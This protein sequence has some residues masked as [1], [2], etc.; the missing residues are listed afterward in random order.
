[1][2]PWEV[3]G[4]IFGQKNPNCIVGKTDDDLGKPFPT[5]TGQRS[6]ELI[7]WQERDNPFR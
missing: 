6:G 1:M 5:L 2:E 3:Y 7:I 4:S